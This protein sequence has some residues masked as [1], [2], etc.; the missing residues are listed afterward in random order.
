MLADA[1]WPRRTVVLLAV[2]CEGG[3]AGAACFFGWLFGQPPL[4]TVSWNAADAGIGIAAAAPMLACFFLCLYAPGRRFVDIREL[5]DRELRPVFQSCTVLDL[6]LIAALAGI[7]EE[8]LFRGVLQAKFVGWLGVPMGIALGSIL[9]GLVHPITPMYILFAAFLGGYLGGVWLWT[10][11]LLSPIIAHAAYDLFALVW[12]LRW[13][14][15][16]DGPSGLPREIQLA[17]DDLHREGQLPLS[18]DPNR[19]IQ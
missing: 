8:M 5:I 4:A 2:A 15:P 7:G 16:R 1:P 3:L 19:G 9:F 11:N 12:L 13:R 10:G 14:R 18:E 17:C 6:M